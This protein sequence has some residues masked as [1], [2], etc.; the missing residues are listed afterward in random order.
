MQIHQSVKDVSTSYDPL[1]EL[2]ESIENFITR[3]NIY[4]KVPPTRPMAEINVKIM[5]E[6]LSI[7]ALVTKQINQNRPSKCGLA[8]LAL[9]QRDA[10]KLVKKLSGENEVE[11]VLRR[12]DRLTLDEDRTTAEHA[13]EV[14]YGLM[15]NMRVV[16]DGGK[17]T[18]MACLLL[19]AELLP[20]DGN[21]SIDSVRDVLGEF[22]WRHKPIRC[23]NES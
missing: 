5:V 9:S 10:V 6:L 8:H 19:P 12:L 2:L 14:V 16:I 13:L 7:L 17:Q 3:L 15:Q 22:C 23:L 1:V 20:V 4:T 11:A 18:S 21:A